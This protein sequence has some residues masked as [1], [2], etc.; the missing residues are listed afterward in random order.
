[1][2]MNAQLTSLFRPRGGATFPP[3][4]ERFPMQPLPSLRFLSRF[5][6]LATLLPL[7]ACGGKNKGGG[8]GGAEGGPG[9][10]P[11]MPP[12]QVTV[13]TLKSEAVTLTRELPGRTNAVTEAEVRPQV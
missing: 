5:A 3:L 13:V 11:Q 1:M 7:V 4:L 8:P 12:A 9:G 6:L 10:M 2:R